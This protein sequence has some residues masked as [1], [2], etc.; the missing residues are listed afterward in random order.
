MQRDYKVREKDLLNYRPTFLKRSKYDDYLLYPV[1]AGAPVPSKPVRA[2]PE[3]I[4]NQEASNE[5]D[6]PF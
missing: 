5:D 4:S 6:L 2:K 3:P 1:P